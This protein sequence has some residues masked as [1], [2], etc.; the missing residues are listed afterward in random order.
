[1]LSRSSS[2]AKLDLRLPLTRLAGYLESQQWPNA[3]AVAAILDRLGPLGDHVQLNLPLE[4][5]PARRLEIELLAGRVQATREQRFDL[6]ERLA[7]RGL[8]ARDKVCV[9]RA[10]HEQ[11]L[12]ALSL[13][14]VVAANFYLKLCFEEGALREVKA[15][16]GWMPKVLPE[17]MGRPLPE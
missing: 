14:A 6:L 7:E 17:F 2:P 10:L 12:T 5:Y 13:G 3:I 11:P 15:Y 1:M 4:P 16:V 8:V 9:L